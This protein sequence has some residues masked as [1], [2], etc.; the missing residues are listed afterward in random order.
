MG[1][2]YRMLQLTHDIQDKEL[3]QDIHLALSIYS[4]SYNMRTGVHETLFR[5]VIQMLGNK[6]Q[7]EKW[8]DSIASCEIFGCFAMVNFNIFV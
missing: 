2:I 3:L 7:N 5:N 6:Q 4:P 1:Q 8:L